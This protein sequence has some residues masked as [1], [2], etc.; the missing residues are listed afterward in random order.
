[1]FI[2]DCKAF[3]QFNTT[4]RINRHAT[5]RVSIIF[6]FCRGQALYRIRCFRCEKSSILANHQCYSREDVMPY[7]VLYFLLSLFSSKSFLVLPTNF[8]Y[9][10]R[11]SPSFSYCP[12]LRFLKLV[13]CILCLYN[14]W[15]DLLDR[16]CSKTEQCFSF[17]APWNLWPLYR[18]V[19]RMIACSIRLLQMW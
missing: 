10:Y 4:Y 7:R 6:I 8:W 16:I 1:M 15:L 17:P 3:I 13:L 18:A 14:R 2:V 19:L 11:P 12:R 5:L 9:K